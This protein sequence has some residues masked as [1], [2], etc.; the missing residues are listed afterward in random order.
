[1][2]GGA[3]QQETDIQAKQAAYYSVLTSQAQQE[4]GNSSK[5]FQDLTSTFE[6]ILKA[7]PGQ[8]G[9]TTGELNN[10]NS[11]AATTQGKSYATTEQAVN[12]QLAATGAGM[13]PSG[14]ATQIRTGLAGS[15]AQNLAGEQQQI[16]QQDYNVGHENWLTAAQAL[17]G[18]TAVYNPATGAAG[19][20]NQGGSAAAQT[21]EDISAQNNSWE[22]LVGG[23][24]GGVSSAVGSFYG[25]KCWVAARIWGGWEKPE[26]HLVRRYIFTDFNRTWYGK[27]LAN[28]YE[29]HGQWASKHGIIVSVL[30]PFFRLALKKAQRKY[31]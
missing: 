1:M 10:L 20:A 15:A 12:R 17:S 25:A 19:A 18:S 16:K 6:P 26:V 30:K 13:L 14:V 2:C 29:K 27:I 7:G 3:S 8:E 22:S 4:F 5:I 24:L 31:N 21:A 9:F 11:I 28:L 23:V